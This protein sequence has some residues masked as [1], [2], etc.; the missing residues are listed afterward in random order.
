MVVNYTL[1]PTTL[2]SGRPKKTATFP[3]YRYLLGP[4]VPLTL[5]PLRKPKG[6]TGVTYWQQQPPKPSGQQRT[7]LLAAPP[8]HF[9][10]LPGVST[11]RELNAALLNHIIP[12]K[13]ADVR[14]L[15]SSPSEKL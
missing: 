9:P 10:E 4:P 8:P 15:S 14:T 7:L 3:L 1:R 2:L 5:Q 13:P 12:G 11:L 6:I